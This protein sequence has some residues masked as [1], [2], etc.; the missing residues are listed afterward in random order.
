MV[1]CSTAKSNI[2]RDQF[3]L[4][5]FNENGFVFIFLI[6]TLQFLQRLFGFALGLQTRIVLKYVSSI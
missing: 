2:K 4:K 5:L 6:G 3:V 1:E